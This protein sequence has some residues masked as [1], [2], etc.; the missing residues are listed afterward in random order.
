MWCWRR[1]VKVWDWSVV[2]DGG[3]AGESG[4]DGWEREDVD[5]E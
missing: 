4:G 1:S 2:G 3:W 5:L